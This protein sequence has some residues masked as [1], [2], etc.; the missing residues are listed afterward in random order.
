MTAE[1]VEAER[2]YNGVLTLRIPKE[3]HRLLASKA[4]DNGTSINQY[5]MYCLAKT[6]G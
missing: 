6:N 4:K 1:D 2:K 3:L 5:V